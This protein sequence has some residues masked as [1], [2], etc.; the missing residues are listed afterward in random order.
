MDDLISRQ[1]AIEALIRAKE[2]IN[3]GDGSMT[4]TLLT[5]AVI[6]KVLNELPSAREKET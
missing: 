2:P 1:D 5:D 3:N 4:I 6:R